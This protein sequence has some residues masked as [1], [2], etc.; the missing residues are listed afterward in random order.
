MKTVAQNRRAR[1]DYDITDT[2]E[3]GI[4]LTGQEVKAC[5]AGQA[6]LLGAYVSIVDGVITLK[7]AKIAK[8]SHA[9]G[10]DHYVPERERQLL[11]KKSEINKIIS[12]LSEKGVTAIPLEIKA[13]KYI[14]V[15][16]GIGRGRKKMDKRHTI[17]DRDIKKR[18]K[19]GQDY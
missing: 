5:R 7:N 2:F 18:I 9:S 17:K 15:L 19:T 13:G 8:Y 3:A 16:I 11:L 12:T 1:Y 14:K 4:S 10:L 6:H